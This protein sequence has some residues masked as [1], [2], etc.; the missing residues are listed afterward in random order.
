MNAII[1]IGLA[2]SGGKHRPPL[3]LSGKS[4]NWCQNTL[5]LAVRIDVSHLVLGEERL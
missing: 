3:S 4:C 2:R 5:I 1:V